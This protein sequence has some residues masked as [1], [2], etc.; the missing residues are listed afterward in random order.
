M[1]FLDG[2]DNLKALA[3]VQV[4]L[5]CDGV[6]FAIVEY[7]SIVWQISSSH[8]DSYKLA[9]GTKVDDS[10]SILDAINQKKITHS[11]IPSSVYGI[12]MKV[13]AIPI[14]DKNEH[15]CRAFVI[16]LP[17]IHHIEGAFTE[18]AP[19][20]AEMFPSGAFIS[21]SDGTKITKIQ[22]SN[23][24]DISTIKVGSEINK[25]SIAYKALHTAKI[26][27]AD[28]D[29]SEYGCPVRLLAY[30][31]IDNES[32]KVVG[33]MNI[34]RPKKNE[35]DLHNMSETLEN[36]LASISATI[37]ELASS[38]STIYENQ[39]LLNNSI[40]DISVLSD[41]INNISSFIE[42]LANQTK[43][44]GLNASIEAARAGESGKGFGVVAKEIRKL[45]D[46]SKS[47][48]P[49]IQQLTNHIKYK[50]NEII[51]ESEHSLSTTQE[52]AA[53]T[54]EI[55]SSIEEINS[56]SE[57]LAEIANSL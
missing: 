42:Q 28:I 10:S 27:R 29:S 44:L 8:F 1:I 30:P 32:N 4:E 25:S 16:I 2:L 33:S 24:F 6:M 35:L 23:K 47:T 26:Q 55:A 21:L 45:S 17:K 15:C 36:S 11:D 48:V 20:I 34:I 41:E 50:V 56:S 57:K 54:Q 31:L 7:D 43:M 46:Q 3:E 9:I 22:S 39:Q 12:T 49:K 53:S 5:M 51:K 52:Q 40:N 37:E 14:L 19:M 38:S 13:T 18:I